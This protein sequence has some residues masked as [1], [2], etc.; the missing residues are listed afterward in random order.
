MAETA[1]AS[2]PLLPVPTRDQCWGPPSVKPS[3]V[4]YAGYEG[5]PSADAH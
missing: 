2:P 4:E 1:S 3:M 5:A